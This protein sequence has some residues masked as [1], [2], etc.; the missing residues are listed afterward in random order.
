[1]KQAGQ[2]LVLF[3]FILVVFLALTALVMDGGIYMWHWQSLQVDLDNACIA[4]AL[5]QRVGGNAYTA[6]ANSLRSNEVQTLYYDPFELG[7]DGLVIRGIQWH[8][9][10]KSFL[11]G[12]QGPHNFYLAQFM[13]IETMDIAVITRCTIPTLRALPIAVQEPWVLTSLGNPA[14][15]WPILGQGAEA[16]AVVGNDFR[17]GVVPQVW[18]ENTNCDPRTFFEPAPE[19]NSSNVLKDVLRDTILGTAGSPLVPIG[20]YIPHPSGTS[21]KFLV[22]AMEDA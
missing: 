2:T 11:A 14:I 9:S 13:G 10:G 1:M 22:Q 15:T 20:G 5:N 19:V 18:C 4:A 16:I 8:W 12:L 3:A 7:P 21:N 17:G 6:F